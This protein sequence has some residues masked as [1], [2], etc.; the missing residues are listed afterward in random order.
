[1]KWSMNV[2]GGGAGVCVL[3]H[4]GHNAD[5]PLSIGYR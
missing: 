3:L 1:M 5:P 4:N 2:D